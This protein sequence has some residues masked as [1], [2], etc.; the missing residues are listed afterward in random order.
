MQ[1]IYIFSVKF[2]KM[3]FFNIIFYYIF[4]FILIIYSYSSCILS[5]KRF[6]PIY[7]RPLAHII[8]IPQRLALLTDTFLHA[9]LK[10]LSVLIARRLHHTLQQYLLILQTGNLMFLATRTKYSIDWFEEVVQFGVEGLGL[11]LFQGLG[12]EYY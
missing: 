9:M 5:G 7:L 1:R 8:I 6:C 10:I 4:V 2:N 12:H 3:C 11:G